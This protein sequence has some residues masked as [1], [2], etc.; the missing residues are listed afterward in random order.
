MRYTSIAN[1]TKFRP[2]SIL[3]Y[4]AIYLY[5]D[6]RG[7]IFEEKISRPPH[8][9]MSFEVGRG[10]CDEEIDELLLTKCRR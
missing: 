1:S 7:H 6:L 3:N 2:G 9:G 4:A 10:Y 8:R 5:F